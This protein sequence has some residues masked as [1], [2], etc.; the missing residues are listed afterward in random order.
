MLVEKVRGLGWKMCVLTT[1]RGGGRYM[2]G[3]V[4]IELFW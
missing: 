1:E 2:N 4:L 3:R